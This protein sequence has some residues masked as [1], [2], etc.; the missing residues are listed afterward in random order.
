[1]A[2]F[3]SLAQDKTASCIDSLAADSRL[4]VIADKVALARSGQASPMRALDRVA[5]DQ[6]RAAVAVWFGRRQECF[7]AGSRKRRALST[8]QEIAFLR[9]VFVFQQRLVGDLQDGRLTYA[10]F[11]QRRGELLQAAGKEI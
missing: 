4:Q 9:S 10:E 7:E 1:M 5:N 6:E 2:S 8:P 3:G 11:N